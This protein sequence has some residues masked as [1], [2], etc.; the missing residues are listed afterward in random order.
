MTDRRYI[1]EN[2]EEVLRLDL[3]TDGTTVEKHARWAGIKPG[4][5]AA[6]LGCG[7]GKTT[8]HLKQLIG[9]DGCI[10]GIDLAPD[11]V[12]FAKKHYSSEGIEFKCADI[13]DPL[14]KFGHFDFIW[15]RFVLEYYLSSSLDIVKNITNILKPGGILCL[16]DLDHNCLNHYGISERLEHAI[17]GVM[18]TLGKKADFDPYAGRKMYSYLYD[19]EYKNIELH[20]EAHHLIYGKLNSTDEFNW[21]QKVEIAAKN[22]GYPFPEYGGSYNRF[23]E[24]FKECF[25]DPRR[26]TYTPVIICRGQKPIH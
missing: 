2:E 18:H 5:Q 7:S 24:E 4:M 17:Q 13:H 9:P 26:F 25:S 16:I 14:E 20:L 11:R 6:D 1:M 3:K 22:S 21:T 19:L 23:F 12:A 10:L 15:V 8:F